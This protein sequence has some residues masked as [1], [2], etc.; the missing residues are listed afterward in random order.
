MRCASYARYMSCIPQ[1]EIPSDIIR[2]QNE[3]IQ[4]YI[5]LN[6]WELT[7]KYADRKQDMEADDAFREMQKDGVN[8][9]FDMI[10]VDSL[11]RCGANVSYAED[12]LLKSF[13]PAGIHFAVV[14]DDICSMNLTPDEV[15]AYFKRRRDD[16]IVGR[17]R[18]HSRQRQAEGYYTVHDEKYGYLLNDDFKSFSIDTE[19]VPII[20]EVFE[21]VGEKGLT[22]QQTADVLNERGYESPAKHISRVGRKK[23]VV[24]N[25]K[26][27]PGAVKRV[28]GNTAYIGYWYK[29]IDGVQT[30][31]P[32]QPI[33]EQELFDKVA[34][35]HKT[36]VGCHSGRLTENAFIKQIFDKETGSSLIC[37]MNKGENAYQTLSIGFW[38]KDKIEYD[39][40][41]SETV[42][43]IRAEQKKVAHALKL[44]ASES[45]KR[46]YARRKEVYA[47]QAKALYDE[48]EELQKTHLVYYTM[49]ECGDLSDE[50]YENYREHIW[51][52]LME[53]ETVFQ[54]IMDGVEKLEIAFSKRN[55]WIVHYGDI[56]VPD[57]LKKPEVRKWVDKIIIENYE[58]VEVILPSKYT[59]WRELLPDEWFTEGE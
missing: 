4:K 52:E 53:K 55:P 33:I 39:Y 44:I 5:K 24:E 11:F 23:F 17:L 54:N 43:A 56:K 8:R 30:K 10:V 57:K 42:S 37:K 26:W 59:V 13:Y 32:I 45:G 49:R 36:L 12:V 15:A 18:F 21:L 14:E 34:N 50:A 20:R 29:V 28:V 47:R 9:K 6:K 22:Y 7:Q 27:A 51:A 48:M 58:K 35:K 2:Q 16:Y 19:V 31:V 40:V 41:M 25:E 3:R 38:D 46:E 1:K